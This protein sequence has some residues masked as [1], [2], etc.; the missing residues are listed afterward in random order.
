MLDDGRREI[1]VLV[2]STLTGDTT[3]KVLIETG[4]ASS[5]YRSIRPLILHVSETA[6]DE[7][8]G[9]ENNQAD[10]ITRP[11][12]SCVINSAVN[13][14]LLVTFE[15]RFEPDGSKITTKGASQPSEATLPP[16]TLVDTARVAPL[17]YVFF[18]QNP[19]EAVADA[20]VRIFRVTGPGTSELAAG[21]LVTAIDGSFSFPA[22]AHGDY[23]VEVEGT[24]TIGFASQESLA[25]LQ[26]N[27]G[28]QLTEASFGFNGGSGVFTTDGLTA[29]GIFDIPVDYVGGRPALVVEKSV[30]QPR[31]EI[32]GLLEYTVSVSNVGDGAA[33]QVVVE[34][35]MPFGFKYIENTLRQDDVRID[36]PVGAP[37]PRL[38]FDAGSLES[39][40]STEFK[41]VLQATSGAIDSD[42]INI[43]QAVG[44][45]RVSSILIES[46]EARV[47]VAVDLSG[48]LSE[49]GI[50]FGKIFVDADC[51]N[52]QSQGEWPVGGVAL[53]LED[54]TYAITD[55]NGQYSIYGVN[56]GSHTIKLDSLTLPEGLNLK[57]IDNRNLAQPGSR[58]VDLQNGEFHRADFAAACPSSDEAEFVY[59]QV[60]ERNMSIQGD[61]LSANSASFDQFERAAAQA[62]LSSDDL[63]SG[64]LFSAGQLG[65][66][67]P[68]FSP[69]AGPIR[70]DL[71]SAAAT[72]VE[73]VSAAVV[74]EE[75]I[76]EITNEQ[77]M[78][79]LWLWPQDD[80]SLYGRFVVAVRDRVEANLYVN[81]ELVSRDQIGEQSHNTAA[82]AQVLAWYGV[83]LQDGENLVEVKT[84]DMF[85]N[86]RLL[87][88]KTFVSP[89]QAVELVVD[90]ERDVLPADGGRTS[91][92]VRISVLDA[93]GNYARGLHFVTVEATDGRLLGE[94][95]QPDTPGMQLRLDR[96]TKEIQLQSSNQTGEVEIRVF[97]DDFDE[98]TIVS[99]IAAQRSLLVSGIASAS[100][101]T[102]SIDSEGYAPTAEE[103]RD[104]LMSDRAALFMKGSV[105]GNLFLT[106]SY[107]SDKAGDG[108]LLRDI[109][110][111][112]Y[113]PIFGDSSVRGYEAQSRSKLFVKLEM[114]RSHLQ[115][116]DFATDRNTEF[117]NLARV[118]RTLTGFSAVVDEGKLKAEVFAAEVEDTRESIE[119]PGNGTAMLFRIEA[120]PIVRNSEIIELV[121]RDRDNSGLIISA[122]NLVRN[123]DYSLDHL[124]GNI[125]FTR[126]V[127]TVDS[128]LNPLSLRISYDLENG[129]GS[130]LVAGARASYEIVEDL[131]VGGSYTT[132]QNASNGFDLSG[133]FVEYKPTDNSRVFVSAAT[134]EHEDG[135]K[136]SGNA[137]Y[138][139]LEMSWENGSSSSLRWGSA[140]VG[141]TNSGS[142]VSADREELSANHNQQIS[143]TLSLDVDLIRSESLSTVDSRNSVEVGVDYS[144]SDWTLSLGGRRIEQE[145]AANPS[146]DANTLI[147]GAGRSFVIFGRRANVNT[148]FEQEVGQQDRKR[149]LV[150]GSY[151]AHENL[152]L[153]GNFEQIN[154]L[155]GPSALNSGEEQITASFGFETDF[156][157]STS[158]FN[159]YRLRGVT[160]GRDLESATGINGDYQIAEGLTINPSIEW[161]DTM[162]GD[163][164]KDSFAISL[165]V[166]DL[167][168]D[169]AR[170]LARI[171]SRF[172]EG[173]DYYGL[174]LSYV[175]RVNLDWSSFAR[176]ELAYS[177]LDD[178]ENEIS[179]ELTLG[180][181]HRPRET[182]KYHALFMYQWR[183]ERGANLLD[184]RSLHLF[185]T[186]Q[187]YQLNEDMRLSGRLGGKYESVPLLDED[188][189]SLT[190]VLDGRLIW[191]VTRRIDFDVHAGVL[192]TNSFSENRYSFGAGVSFLVMEGLRVGIGYNLTGFDEGDL[193]TE[194]Y[195]RQGVY[196]HAEYKFDEDLFHWLESDLYRREGEE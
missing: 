14:T 10:Y 185:S 195:N 89:S 98:R 1:T 140:D 22:L 97:S 194:G 150:G 123:I 169:N 160:D 53:Y 38:E 20:I 79:G 13:D 179:H 86:D 157:P 45:D 171:E 8:C 184:D 161:I 29:F 165:G 24:D 154:S 126:T 173:R 112:E 46:N 68:L 84:Q 30:N 175:A 183:E 50:I 106:L 54:G 15:H 133:A 187:N 117:Q 91:L 39:G 110:P 155:T 78:Q 135:A 61:W 74:V 18:S 95:I 188:F 43:A 37:A 163:S 128:D 111:D 115:W 142:G 177:I 57:P 127:P 119:I 88:S 96:G 2:E 21:P 109:N 108:E 102:C 94:D 92:P 16:V 31:V 47:Q 34:D 9:V 174:D 62:A 192:A 124:S 80:I 138:A 130:D 137:L 28:Y 191:D 148:E 118:Q 170:R 120:A 144:I 77:A 156:L 131:V 6:T 58:L 93:S 67:D 113:Y 12:E 55:E 3:E 153:Y 181:T 141:F 143:K 121:T 35:L 136:E 122:V 103:C 48:V 147:A 172:D 101:G 26:A 52:I 134:M 151:Q 41:Y 132:D 4:Y 107:D 87:L 114:D 66:S 19:Y 104:G 129:S 158:V 70:N 76:Y 168:S 59:A 145:S 85:G 166:E 189:S 72:T 105:R 33:D 99:F 186:H 69:T 71:D 178:S 167:R 196:L 81:G 49:K 73:E 32:G 159:E 162:E 90:P 82:D 17:G 75:V 116:G 64:R 139:E 27:S 146:D 83:R 7:A 23:Y 40:E 100:A 176:E 152:K 51:N 164:D 63:S 190:A 149:W 36:D 182:N 56:P 11:N 180:L 65:S 60:A 193:D 44:S 5:I 25:D 125:R 42:G